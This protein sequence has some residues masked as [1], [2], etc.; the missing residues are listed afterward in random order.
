[1]LY[2]I[3]DVLFRK[4]MQE[5][6]P[7][8][9]ENK[10]IEEAVKK[11]LDIQPEN[12][13]TA[14]DLDHIKYVKI[15][16]SSHFVNGFEIQL[17]TQTPPE[18]FS[19]TD[20]GDEWID[21]LRGKDVVKFLD[22]EDKRRL[23]HPSMFCFGN[24]D[25]RDAM[26]DDAQAAWNEY[27]TNI[28]PG[29]DFMTVIQL[30]QSGGMEATDKRFELLMNELYKDVRNFTGVQVLRIYELMIPDYSFFQNMKQ[31]KALELVSVSFTSYEGYECLKDL[32]QFACWMD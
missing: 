17:S 14:E 8:E 30:S 10:W 28:V 5:A 20:G 24:E 25:Y 13:L 12:E 15:G 21:C 19:D 16:T 29:N 11:V 27:K 23:L 22:Q 9:F 31:L 2:N 4:K 1:M 7:M 6:T 32:Q 3:F 26:S 18:P